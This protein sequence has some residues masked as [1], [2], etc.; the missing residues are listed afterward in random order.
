MK[1]FVCLLS[2][3]ILAGCSCLPSQ[4]VSVAAVPTVRAPPPTDCY[5]RFRHSPRRH[6]LAVECT[7]AQLEAKRVPGRNYSHQDQVYIRALGVAQDVDSGRIDEREA[8]RRLRAI[9]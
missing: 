3:L 5:K 8:A 9:K 2:V 6:V 4:R 1:P 7:E